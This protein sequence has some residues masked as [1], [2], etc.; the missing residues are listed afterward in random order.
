MPGFTSPDELTKTFLPVTPIL[1][2][3]NIP[4]VQLL[5]TIEQIYSDIGF[6]FI[7]LGHLDFFRHLSHSHQIPLRISAIIH[8]MYMK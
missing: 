6:S 2:E 8:D 4:N 1:N 3:T 5:H 7:D